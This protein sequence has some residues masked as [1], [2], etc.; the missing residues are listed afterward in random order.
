MANYNP[1]D[2]LVEEITRASRL[3]TALAGLCDD[4]TC[5]PAA[6]TGT[7]DDASRSAPP[8]IARD[9]S[10][11]LATLKVGV[12]ELGGRLEVVAVFPGQRVPLLE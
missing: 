11:F 6:G 3:V 10:I 8:Q 5:E 12:E 9:D 1:T 2:P 7:P 4:A